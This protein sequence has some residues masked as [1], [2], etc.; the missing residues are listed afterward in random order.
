MFKIKP[1]TLRKITMSFLQR[2]KSPSLTN[3]SP[4]LERSKSNERPTSPSGQSITRN[5]SNGNLRVTYTTNL[6]VLN[7]IIKEVLQKLIDN[8]FNPPIKPDDLI[9]YM[10]TK[11]SDIYKIVEKLN[12]KTNEKIEN[13]KQSIKAAV[14]K[15]TFNS[16]IPILEMILLQFFQTP[17]IPPDILKKELEVLTNGRAL[18]GNESP[19]AE[20]IN[21]WKRAQKLQAF[22][23]LEA[24]NPDQLSKLLKLY[25]LQEKVQR[26]NSTL[27]NEW[28]KK[29]LENRDERISTHL[30][31]ESMKSLKEALIMDLQKSI[32][33]TP[34]SLIAT[35]FELVKQ[36]YSESLEFKNKVSDLYK[37]RFDL[38]TFT[39]EQKKNFLLF[40]KNKMVFHSSSPWSVD[41]KS[42]EL[43]SIKMGSTL[44]VSERLL[45]NKTYLQTPIGKE[46]ALH[47]LHKDRKSGIEYLNAIIKDPDNVYPYLGN[48]VKAWI[49]EV[50]QSPEYPT[51]QWIIEHLEILESFP[52]DFFS[53]LRALARFNYGKK[54]AYLV[55]I[56]SLIDI[57]KKNENISK[58]VAE[59]EAYYINQDSNDA[60]NLESNMKGIATATF[61]ETEITKLHT[62]FQTNKPK[63]NKIPEILEPV[64]SILDSPKYFQIT[65]VG[66][67]LKFIPLSIND[68]N[69]LDS[70]ILHHIL[71]L[72][73]LAAEFLDRDENIA[74]NTL[75]TL[76]KNIHDH[77]QCSHHFKTEHLTFLDS[78]Y[79][80]TYNYV[81]EHYVIKK[82]PSY[83]LDQF[84]QAVLEEANPWF[85]KWI[86]MAYPYSKK[87][88]NI[89]E[90]LHKLSNIEKDNFLRF[91]L[92]NLRNDKISFPTAG[93]PDF[94]SLE[95]TLN[96]IISE[97]EH[98]SHKDL[99]E[100][101]KKH[102][103]RLF[104][105]PQVLSLISNVVKPNANINGYQDSYLKELVIQRTRIEAEISSKESLSLHLS[106]KVTQ[107]EAEERMLKKDHKQA[108]VDIAKTL[109][110]CKNRLSTLNQDLNAVITE[111]QKFKRKT[112]SI[113]GELKVSLWQAI[114]RLDNS[115]KILDDLITHELETLEKLPKDITSIL[116][117]IISQDKLVAKNNALRKIMDIPKEKLEKYSDEPKIILKKIRSLYH[118]QKTLRD[119]VNSLRCFI[120]KPGWILK[121]PKQEDLEVAS[122]MGSFLPHYIQNL[123]QEDF[124]IISIKKDWELDIKEN[125]NIKLEEFKKN[126]EDYY[127]LS[128]EKFAAKLI[129]N[130]FDCIDD[131]SDDF[132]VEQLESYLLKPLESISLGEFNAFQFDDKTN[133]FNTSPQFIQLHRRFEKI[134]KWFIPYT[135]CISQNPKKIIKKWISITNLALKKGYFELYNTIAMS[136]ENNIKFEAIEGEGFKKIRE[137]LNIINKNHHFALTNNNKMPFRIALEEA[138]NEGKSTSPFITTFTSDLSIL[139]DVDAFNDENMLNITRMKIITKVKDAFL[140]HPSKTIQE[141]DSLACIFEIFM[142]VCCLHLP[143][144]FGMIDVT[145]QSIKDAPHLDRMDSSYDKLAKEAL[146]F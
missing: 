110:E 132:L 19:L 66:N 37:D 88:N 108:L 41:R 106:N 54:S 38:N 84:L 80:I 34:P 48:L 115:V 120:R 17:S 76:L 31:H 70:K 96:L 62:A 122:N 65:T 126:L 127:T 103:K 13:P 46:I 118:K 26:V 52:K 6:D 131:L 116:G 40:I 12:P 15:S 47:F 58:S 105:S 144:G 59:L 119:V 11:V 114:H 111:L 71:I 133:N 139:A 93:T 16:L 67:K 72:I 134:Q 33:D 50:S 75:L 94:A 107:L 146:P 77:P 8:L 145:T 55:N 36:L 97:N 143:E 135:I 35:E 101:I 53:S 10:A 61:I 30:N 23:E 64:F 112:K 98:S 2:A 89:F 141:N 138:F 142:E 95:I 60:K 85:A 22:E 82:L 136:L 109:T 14:K 45:E 87:T 91:V 42:L 1:N 24:V 83:T 137:K 90:I 44:V 121:K 99:I 18:I 73:Q 104:H 56:S 123:K 39:I 21:A 102:K 79:N 25:Q 51:H 27:L 124:S 117:M 128:Q 43:D 7:Q 68:S 69:K 81:D 49:Q 4:K 9:K 5:F 86:T 113:K 78:L 74:D 63:I 100:E 57:G 29:F 140:K 20:K 130:P 32:L 129:S 92:Y 3:Q 125:Q 28:E